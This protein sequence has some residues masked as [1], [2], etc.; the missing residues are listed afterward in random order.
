MSKGGGPTRTTRVLI[1]VA[2]TL[3]VLAT[4][5]ILG[6]PALLQATGFAGPTAAGSVPPGFFDDVPAPT[7]G[8]VRVSPDAVATGRSRDESPDAAAVQR[9]IAAVPRAGLGDAG[10]TFVSARTG[11]SLY[12]DRADEL[13]VPASTLKVLTSVAALA[14]LGPETTFTTSVVRSGPGTIVLV[15]GGDPYLTDA[16]SPDYPHAASLQQLAQS[17]ADALKQA[18]TKS[19]VLGYDESLFS[20]PDWHPDWTDSYLSEVAHIS[21]LSIDGG[22][23]Q[24]DL[25]YTETAGVA[26]TAFVNRLKANGIAVTRAQRMAAPA[27]AP[28]VAAVKSVPVSVIVEQV[29]LHSDNYGAEV[30]ARQ[31]A[32]AGGRPGTFDDGAAAV[33]GQ[34][35]KLGLLDERA[36][37][38]DG[39]GL[40]KKNQVTPAMLAEAVRHCLDDDRLSAVVTGL[41]LAGVSGTLSNRYDTDAGRGNVWAK[42]GFLAGIHGLAG[43]LVTTDGD[44]VVFAMLVNGQASRGVAQPILDALTSAVAGCGCR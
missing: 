26:A 3:A 33:S 42:T 22:R 9:R 36:I 28:R 5:T 25:P 4:G 40:S 37:I 34:L 1:A 21:A 18:G 10:M 15:G 16:T 41:P 29:L 17:T 7:A 32:I 31:V 43:V 8:E 2:A 39:S 14:A 20:G 27:D 30:L 24:Y 19:V 23:S 12:S 38:R 6:G 13:F 11:D 44:T 35:A